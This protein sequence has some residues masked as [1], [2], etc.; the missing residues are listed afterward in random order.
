MPLVRIDLPQGK[1][2]EYRHSV[3]DVVYEAMRTTL[4]VPENDR[5]QVITEHAPGGLVID[6]TY[7]G[8]ARSG[9]ALMIQVTLNAGRSVELKKAFYKAVADGLHERVGLRREDVLI[10][11]VEVPKE[12]WSFGNGE[13]QYA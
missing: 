11:L 4:N 2:P 7:L 8:I 13:A 3:G 9:D 12:N 1:S 5:F 6:P 10:Q